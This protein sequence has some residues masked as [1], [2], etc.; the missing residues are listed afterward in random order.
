MVLETVI[1]YVEV[2]NNIIQ[3]SLLFFAQVKRQENNTFIKR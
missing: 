3:R 1:V 2:A